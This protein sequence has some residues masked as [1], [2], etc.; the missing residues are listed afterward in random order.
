MDEKLL[1]VWGTVLVS[2]C[3]SIFNVAAQCH[4]QSRCLDRGTCMVVDNW[5]CSFQNRVDEVGQRVFFGNHTTAN[6][7]VAT[8]GVCAAGQ[9][10]TFSG[11]RVGCSRRRYYPGALNVEVMTVQ[12]IVPHKKY[13]GRWIHSTRAYQGGMMA[14]YDEEVV[15]R[16]V[17]DVVAGHYR[18]RVGSS[19]PS[20]FYHA[21]VRMLSNNAVAV[22]EN[23]AFD[24]LRAQLVVVSRRTLLRSVGALARHYCDS[25]V[26]VALAFGAAPRDLVFN[27]TGGVTLTAAEVIRYLH[28]MGIDRETQNIA[29]RFADRLAVVETQGANGVSFSLS[30]SDAQELLHNVD[31]DHVLGDYSHLDLLL[32]AYDNDNDGAQAYMVGMAARCALG[33]GGVVFGAPGRHEAARIGIDQLKSQADRLITVDTTKLSDAT[34]AT[35][36]GA[37]SRRQL[38]TAIWR[39]APQVCGE[40]LVEFFPDYVDGVVFETLVSPT[41]YSRLGIAYDVIKDAVSQA[42]LT[43]LISTVLADPVKVAT[44]A[45]DVDLRIAGAPTGSWA[46]R[47]IPLTPP[48]LTSDDGAL[49]ILLKTSASRFRRR[50]RLVAEGGV[51]DLPPLYSST[52]RNAYL[53]PRAG[54][55]MLLPGIIVPPFADELYDDESLY[56]RIGWILAHEISHVTADAIWHA[57]AVSSLLHN[58]TPNTYTEALADVVATQAISITGMVYKSALC[59]H[60]SQMWC[61]YEEDVWTTHQSTHPPRNARSDILCMMNDRV[62]FSVPA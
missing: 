10:Q 5:S 1:I 3:V 2:V 28:T 50:A 38:T 11:D 17:I 36:G 39:Q 21:C 40:G 30:G 25:A 44:D 47:L 12:S 35:F 49:V 60:L 20:K 26:Q 32:R 41:L 57:S 22:S 42:I 14:F 18:V 24:Y 62:T 59:G 33:V 48:E 51:C 31:G 52:T 19:P 7:F 13:C 56:G 34:S 8:R 58:Y 43:P 23:L 55:A 61:G 4:E 37:F 29:S 15:A 53:F 16:D 9:T 45:R 54:C 27:L 46:G 6:F